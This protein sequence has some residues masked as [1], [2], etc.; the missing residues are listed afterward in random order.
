[1]NLQIFYIGIFVQPRK[2]LSKQTPVDRELQKYV[3][4]ALYAYIQDISL[5]PT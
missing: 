3:A 5:D 4:G 2:C 1:M